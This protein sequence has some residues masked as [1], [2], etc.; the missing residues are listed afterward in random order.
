MKKYILVLWPE[1]QNF[2]ECEDCVPHEE[3]ALF[4]PEEVYEMW[5]PKPCVKEQIQQLMSASNEAKI[6]AKK[7]AVQYV[8]SAFKHNEVVRYYN[9]T[10]TLALNKI[11]GVFPSKSTHGEIIMSAI[12]PDGNIVSLWMSAIH[13]TQLLSKEDAK[14]GA[15]VWWN[16]PEH[17]TCGIYQIT[18]VPKSLEDDSII[19]ISSGIGETEV[20]LNELAKI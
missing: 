20:T 13:K 15:K 18:S 12:N 9:D 1:S 3:G 11:T 6:N 2:M 5:R 7:L 17:K 4:V 19:M 10:Y 14:K 16:D 8:Y